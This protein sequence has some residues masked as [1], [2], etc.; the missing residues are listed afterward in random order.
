M[1]KILF[2]ISILAIITSCKKN[3]ANT[4]TNPLS[5]LHGNWK[6]NTWC[7]VPDNP[8]FVNISESS[9]NGI[10]DSIG[11]GSCNYSKGEII[12]SNITATTNSGVFSCNAIFKYGSGNT[13]IAQTTATLTLQNSNQIMWVHYQ[14]AS[15]I[16]P[17]D[18]Y[19]T[20]Q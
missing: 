2:I 11:M 20:K 10:V 3:N 5:A 14:P 19:Y 8:I 18:F 15:G 12:F 16:Q 17:P 1:K 6:F 4:S 9:Q 7:G 13:N